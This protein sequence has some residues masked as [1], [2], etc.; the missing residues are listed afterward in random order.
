[1]MNSEIERK[2]KTVQRYEKI[3]T[4]KEILDNDSQLMEQA[5]KFFKRNHSN[6][7]KF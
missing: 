6:L 4:V 5:G 3:G 1:M 2:N 7:K